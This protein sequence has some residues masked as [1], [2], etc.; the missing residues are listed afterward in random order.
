M[1]CC[2]CIF[3]LTPSVD[4][5]IAL[6]RYSWSHWDGAFRIIVREHNN[7][8]GTREDNYCVVL[9]TP[10]YQDMFDTL[11]KCIEKR[12]RAQQEHANDRV[13]LQSEHQADQ[14][15]SNELIILDNSANSHP[16]EM[17]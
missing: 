5:L 4:T 10:H 2:S 14:P 6:A 13:K 11:A 16:I 3:E 15:C 8:A 9:E 17:F 12:L 1:L 7:N